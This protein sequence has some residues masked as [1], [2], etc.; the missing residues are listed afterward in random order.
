MTNNQG[1]SIA[2]CKSQYFKQPNVRNPLC[3]AIFTCILLGRVFHCLLT[4]AENLQIITPL[5]WPGFISRIHYRTPAVVGARF[6]LRG[7]SNATLSNGFSIV[8]NLV[9]VLLGLLLETVNLIGE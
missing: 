2:S 7:G 3:L 6:G 1:T 8:L 9:T 4:H 5:A